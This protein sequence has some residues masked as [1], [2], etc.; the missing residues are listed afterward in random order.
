YEGTSEINNLVYN[1]EYSAFQVKIFNWTG[2][3][4]V[5]AKGDATK[6]KFNISLC[7]YSDNPPG[8]QIQSLGENIKN[9][10]SNPEELS[11]GDDNITD[12][13]KE[14][15]LW[16]RVNHFDNSSLN[17]TIA[18]P[19]LLDVTLPS[20]PTNVKWGD[21]FTV[22]GKV[23]DGQ[24]TGLKS[25]NVRVYY[26][27]SGG[28]RYDEDSTPSTVTTGT[29]SLL[30][31]TGSGKGYGA[32]TWYV[33]TYT[34][35]GTGRVN[36]SNVPPYI[37]GF[38]PYYSFKVGSKDT[39][40]VTVHSPDEL[41]KGFWQTINISVKNES[42]MTE[43]EF[44][45]M[46]IHIT[47]LK[48]WN[49]TR[50]YNRSDIVLLEANPTGGGDTKCYYEFEYMFNETGTATIWVSW[51]GNLTSFDY[52]DS[53][54]SNTYGNHNT[55]LIANITGKITVSVVSP[56]A[57]T[58]IVN[59]PPEAV[60]VESDFDNG[61]VNKST[62]W[63]NIS[64]YGVNQSTHKNATIKVTGCGLDFTINESDKPS[65]NKY[66]IENG[67]DDVGN[68][69][70]YNISI[71]PKM[72]GILTITVTNGSN[73]V[74]KDYTVKGLT[75]TVTTSIGDDLEITVG[76]TETITLTGVNQYAQVTVTF[77]DEN[78]GNKNKL[79]YSE[80]AGEFSFTPD[81]DD[82]DRIGYIVVVAGVEVWD[83]YMYDIIEVVPVDDL[84][85]NV[86]TPTAGN[87]TLTVGL[88][89][90]VI[91]ELLDPNGNPVTEDT[92]GIDCR[93]IDEDHD[94][95]DY[96][97]EFTFTSI[98]DGQWEATILPWTPGQLV[99]KGY[100]ASDG[101]KHI[102]SNTLD[103][104]YA[105]ISYSPEGATAGIE[106]ENLTVAVTA[107][108]AN[109]NPLDVTLYLWAENDTG[110]LKFDDT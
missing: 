94:W 88:E 27:V 16:V 52:H 57:M 109:G 64:V 83:L 84:Q 10:V 102:G 48:G 95:D 85:L 18:L 101:I 55:S 4:L 15:T 77:F 44:K 58:V 43:D 73:T 63:T 47:G 66:L 93:L 98:G 82:I 103:V 11:I 61:W 34:G 36:K 26:P 106:I 56:G 107:K 20:P 31:E 49:G 110:E 17:S 72:A 46:N 40:T 41:T 51:P 3:Q 71:I 8:E 14:K 9:G 60:E 13:D 5:E 28:Y 79:N 80:E 6:Y 105:V 1:K 42:W 54:Y 108:D 38:I 92:P 59:N 100:N 87:Q 29:Y 69:S 45:N 24:G 65:T 74:I 96:L 68:G 23:L 37:D 35:S 70:W 7:N 53:S 89:Q 25:Y 62:A 97:Q 50:A 30:I 33:G 39:A 75:G 81:A 76:T 12:P 2:S 32:G 19:V 104:D 78:W 22:S 86:L 21:S 91:I 99:I 90:D 67:F